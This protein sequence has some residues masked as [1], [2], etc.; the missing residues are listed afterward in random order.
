MKLQDMR[1]PRHLKWPLY[2]MFGIIVVSFVFF[3]GWQHQNQT[4]RD[5]D[6]YAKIRS[7]SNNPFKRWTYIRRPQVAEAQ[8]YRTNYI[9][10]TYLPQQWVQSLQ[11]QGTLKAVM[12][13]LVTTDEVAREAANMILMERAARDLGISISREDIIGQ[14]S[15]IPNMSDQALDNQVREFGM[16]NRNEFLD[17]IRRTSEMEQVKKLKEIAAQASLFELWQEYGLRNDKFT[18]QIAAFPNDAFTSKV[19]VTDQDVQKYYD[20][21]R[22]D[23]RIPTQRRYLYI[24][25]TRD[26]ISKKIAPAEE[27]IDAFHKANAERYRRDQAVKLNELHLTVLPGASID[28]AM[29]FMDDLRTTATATRDWAAIAEKTRDRAKA[30]GNFYERKTEWLSAG[31]A[32]R[33]ASY[34]SRVMTLSG[35]TV[36]TP[37][38]TTQVE[39]GFTTTVLLARVIERRAAGV[40]PLAEIHDDVKRDFTTQET[41]RLFK[42]RQTQWKEARDKAKNMAEL[43][44]TLGVDDH[45]TTMVDANNYKIEGVGQFQD[46]SDYVSGLTPGTPSDPIPTDDG[47][48]VVLDPTDMVE[49]HI[50]PLPEVRS[51]IVTAIQVARSGDLARAAAQNALQVVQGGAKFDNALADAPVKPTLTEPQTRMGPVKVLQA[52]LIDFQSQ[53]LRAAR[54][55]TGMSPFGMDKNNPLGY[56]VWRVDDIQP[57]GKD[58]FAAQRQAFTR[59]YVQMQQLSLLNEWLKDQRAKADFELDKAARQAAESGE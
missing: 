27:Q 7:E 54:N 13:R 32:D 18:L 9:Q 34:M 4:D 40:A 3:Y 26:D 41:D 45:I 28:S 11:R 14:L 20:D 33:P 57:V 23:Y 56:A 19:L 2:F 35:D 36:S 44:K 38:L 59:D 51:K 6:I 30:I 10:Q 52:P 21:H 16:R 24:K 43:A 50:P 31:T 12:E 8:I 17:Y 39:D 22:E 25:L 5:L 1:N 37:I 48:L 42:E 53:T 47:N 46:N 15:S 58:E 49:S 29:K 55:T